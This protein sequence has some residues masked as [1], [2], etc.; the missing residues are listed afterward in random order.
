MG[1][2]RVL[3]L[4]NNAALELAIDLKTVQSDYTDILSVSDVKL[5]S[6]K[7]MVAVTVGASRKRRNK[8]LGKSKWI[9]VIDILPDRGFDCAL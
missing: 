2:G 1:I 4:F 6:V 5:N 9:E 7:K 3:S 8:C